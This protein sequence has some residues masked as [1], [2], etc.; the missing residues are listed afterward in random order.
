MGEAAQCRTICDDMR[1]CTF[2]TDTFR[3]VTTDFARFTLTPQRM[4]MI[5]EAFKDALEIG[6]EKPEQTVVRIAPR[7]PLL[8]AF[9][10]RCSA[11]TTHP[12]VASQAWMAENGSKPSGI[13]LSS[14]LRRNAP[15]AALLATYVSWS[16]KADQCS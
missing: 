13:T 8:C 3:D 14:S 1:A 11:S 16:P 9:I 5:V 10:E 4:R 15:R 6:L 12:G 7:L 2:I